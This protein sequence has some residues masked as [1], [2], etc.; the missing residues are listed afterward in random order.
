MSAGRLA[1]IAGALLLEAVVSASGQEA[2]QIGPFARVDSANPCL[3]PSAALRF[4]CPLRRRPV[5]WA[6]KDVFNPAAVVRGKSIYLLYRA[7]DSI[8]R[9][10]GTSR[11]GIAWSSDG[12]KFTRNPSPVL[13][14]DDDFMK[15]YEWEGGCEDPRV[16]RSRTGTYV[17]TYTAF[18]GRTAR[19]AVATSGDLFHW[20][21]EGL[22]F[23]EALGGKY[24][25]FWS[26][27]GSIVAE[28]RGED[29]VAVS[30]QG[31]FWM[32][33]GEGSVHLA[34]SEDLVRWIPV[35][36]PKGDLA[37]VLAPRPHLFDSHLVEPGPPAILEGT[38]I[39]FI[40]N[41]ANDRTGGDP[42]LPPGAYSAGQALFAADDPG[43][44]L[45]RTTSNFF[46]PENPGEL[47]GQVNNVCFLEGLAPFRGRW[48]LYYGEAD[49][50]VG[51]A[52]APRR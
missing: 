49:S 10:A 44:L 31:R 2:W 12:L 47:S 14:P 3:L 29:L 34:V 16:V 24:R 52:V 6:S 25:D 27:S 4:T 15:Q 30:I 9:P 43:R 5:A 18:D 38:G 33:W 17:M 48:L 23:G 13:Y 32:Y 36:D 26:K 19:L 41:G 8:G 22:A 50:R 46:H 42:A 28:I 39:L 11:I 20:K 7:Q 45:E 1:A 40:Y 51:V 35:E 21:K 37:V